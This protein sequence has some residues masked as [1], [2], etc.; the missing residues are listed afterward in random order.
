MLT[1]LKYA[2]NLFNIWNGYE[3]QRIQFQDTSDGASRSCSFHHEL[4]SLSRNF[5]TYN[6]QEI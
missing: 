6:S 5:Q 1:A 3:N 2:V 4:F